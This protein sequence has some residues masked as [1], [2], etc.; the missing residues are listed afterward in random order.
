MTGWQLVLRP[1]EIYS[2]TVTAWQ[3]VRPFVWNVQL[4]RQSVQQVQ[5]IFN[6]NW[7]LVSATAKSAV[8]SLNSEKMTRR[9]SFHSDTFGFL[10]LCIPT[11]SNSYTFQFWHCQIV[12]LSDSDTFSSLLCVRPSVRKK[13]VQTCPNTHKMRTP[14]SYTHLTLPTIYSV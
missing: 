8:I 9:V 4:L 14:V 7:P 5:L 11:H 3:L 6:F 1:S 13:H 2:C 12:M 10:H